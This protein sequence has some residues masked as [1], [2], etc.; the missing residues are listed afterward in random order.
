MESRAIAAQ[1]DGTGH[2]SSSESV[3]AGP[4]RACVRETLCD[5]FQKLNGYECADLYRLVL[6]EVESPLLEIVMRECAGNQSKA[7]RLLGINRGTLRKKLRQYGM[8]G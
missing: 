2:S 8:D 5:Y 7:A 1:S 4:I 6:E 3:D